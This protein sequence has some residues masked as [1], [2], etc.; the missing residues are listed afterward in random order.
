MSWCVH[1]GGAGFSDSHA[2]WLGLPNDLLAQLQHLS[3]V[4]DYRTFLR[5]QRALGVGEGFLED[6]QREIP[7]GVPHPLV[8]THPE[9]G[10]NSLCVPPPGP[11]ALR[12]R[13]DPP[14]IALT[15]TSVEEFATS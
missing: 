5:A 10:K 7:F 1:C 6:L 2:A 11:S 3:A 4:H 15:R 8:R 14:S 12:C 13:T 9:T